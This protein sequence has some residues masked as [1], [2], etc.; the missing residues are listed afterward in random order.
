MSVRKAC[1]AINIGVINKHRAFEIKTNARA[2]LNQPNK[3]SHLPKIIN[4]IRA[5]QITEKIRAIQINKK[6]S[7]YTNQTNDMFAL[8][9]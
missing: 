3:C 6:C 9:K 2:D 4:K 5:N 1:A 8:P 7:H